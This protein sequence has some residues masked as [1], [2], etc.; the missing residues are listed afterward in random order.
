MKSKGKTRETFSI[1]FHHRWGFQRKMLRISGYIWILIFAFWPHSSSPVWLPSLGLQKWKHT[2]SCSLYCFPWILM[3]IRYCW[4]FFWGLP[5]RNKWGFTCP[6]GKEIF[7]GN[8]Q[9][10]LLGLVGMLRNTFHWT[11]KNQTSLGNTWY[12]SQPSPSY[13]MRILN[14]LNHKHCLFLT[15]HPF[16]LLLAHLRKHKN[17][18][19]YM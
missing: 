4:H 10:W 6:G 2:K 17:F 13:L 7:T 8:A 18:S 11:R 5:V 19:S 9:L 15:Q 16:V 12:P 14:T 3:I 1:S